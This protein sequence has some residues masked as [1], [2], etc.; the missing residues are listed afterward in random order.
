MKIKKAIQLLF[1]LIIVSCNKENTEVLNSPKQTL[2]ESS[3]I[4]GV[5][6]SFIPEIRLKGIQTKNMNGEPED[7]LLTLKN[8]GVNVIRLRLW[9]EPKA[10]FQGFE[11]VKKFSDEIKKHGM[12]VWLTVHYSD[13]WA[14][15]GAQTK[16]EKWNGLG[17]DLLKDSIYIYTKQVMTKI[18]PEYIQIGNEINGG[19]LWPEGNIKNQ[20]QMI[21]LL[22]KASAA[23]R[24]TNVKAKII[25]HHAGYQNANYFYSIAKN[26][27]YDLIGISYYPKWH[28]KSIDSL[29]AQLIQL[30]SQFNKPTVIAETS[31]PFT[32]L[33]NDWTN[34]IIGDTS[35][36]L[37]QFS[38]TPQG[39]RE[40]LSAI[41]N[42]VNHSSI[43]GF[44]Y[45]GAEF[46]SFDG[47][48]SKNGSSWENQAFW[49]FNNQ[50]LPVLKV[51]NE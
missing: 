23:V 36:I 13:T 34:N 35:Q 37:A 27:D 31:Y 38:A 12:K 14:D 42:T 11:E 16:P 33:W 15:P 28:G 1:I 3:M 22:N 50:A 10:I 39:Q 25:L 51:F 6:A 30:Y 8:Q 44:C 20:S 17:L 48:Q 4:K 26:V 40:Y 5:D 2:P 43:I 47:N 19:F 32:F 41:K 7:M 29:K 9:H 45:W 24:E 49:D 46:I 18:N 21:E